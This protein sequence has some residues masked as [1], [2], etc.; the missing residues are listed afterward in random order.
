M[1][2]QI[3]KL[4]LLLMMGVSMSACSKSWKEEVQL[5]DGSKIIVERTVDRGGRHE[6]GQ[7]PPIKNQSVTFTIPS[8]NENVTWEDSFTEDIGGA[9]FLPMQL[10]ILKD[11]AYLLVH[12]MGCLS[13]NKWDRPNPPYVV[14]KYQDKKWNRF[15]LKELPAEFKTPN[16]IFSSPDDEA[17]KAGGNI[18]SAE[19]IKSLYAHYKQPEYKTILREAV[20][21]GVDS[22]SV[23]CQPM[24]HYKCGWAGTNPDGTF[25]KKFLDNVC[26]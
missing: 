12:P 10:E 1:W 24:M 7:E 4:G 17:E 6:I 8:T 21:L 3:T 22:S 5:H 13:Y 26:K 2:K 19:T 11:I 16:L 20:K 14:F 25:N 15:P 23:N 9:N 18:V